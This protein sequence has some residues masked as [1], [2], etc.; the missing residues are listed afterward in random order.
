MATNGTARVPAP[1]HVPVLAAIALA[2]RALAPWRWPTAP[3]VHGIENVPL[4]RPVPFAGNH[5]LM[6]LLDVPVMLLELY[7]IPRPQRFYFRFAPPVE[8]SDLA[9][10][11]ERACGS[12][13]DQVRAAVEAGITFLLHE[14]DR[15]PARSIVRR[16]LAA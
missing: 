9:G 14:R 10:L 2:R 15:D 16:L 1:P 3:R 5:T 6:G 13:R 12:V 4:D 7:A 11:E 8:T